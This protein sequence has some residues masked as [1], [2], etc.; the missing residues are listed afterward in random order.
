MGTVR[1]SRI[2]DL[3]DAAEARGSCLVPH[4]ERDRRAIRRRFRKRRSDLISPV[5]GLY[6]RRSRWR[7]LKPDGRALHVM[8]GLQELRP[9]TVFCAQSAALAW[10]LPVSWHLLHETHVRREHGHRTKSTRRVISHEIEGDPVWDVGGLRVTSFWRTVFDCL[11]SFPFADALAIADAALRRS[12]LAR[13]D[14]TRLLRTR[15]RHCPGVRRAAAI[16]VWAEPAAESGGES[17][18]RA[19]MVEL[20]Y[21]YPHLQLTLPDPADDR[22]AFR[23]DFSW[24]DAAGRLIFGELD[25]D[26]KYLSAEAGPVGT[27][28]DERKREA[29]LTVYRPSIARFSMAVARDPRQLSALLDLHGVPRGP[30]P[31]LHFG[32]VPVP[33]AGF[34]ERKTIRGQGTEIASGVRFRFVEEVCPRD[35]LGHV[36]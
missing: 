14:M 32:D 17:I 8:R 1:H 35:P 5:P 23:V 2:D 26:D 6:V 33:P 31:E 22:R 27:L 15:F 30:A 7:S 28:L 24:R 13:Q 29:L 34:A 4:E 3:L 16:C 18:A 36:A 9:N 19:H 11:T 25:G 12:C 21:E 10:G 20:G